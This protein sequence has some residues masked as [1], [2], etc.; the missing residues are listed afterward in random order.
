MHFVR[1]GAAISAAS[2]GIGTETIAS[3]GR[4]RNLETAAHY[5]RAARRA[6]SSVA[7]GC[8]PTKKPVL[9]DDKN[10][11]LDRIVN[12]LSLNDHNSSRGGH[13]F[14]TGKEVGISGADEPKGPLA[15]RSGAANPVSASAN[16]C[17]IKK[18]D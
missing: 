7:L 2:A 6:A 5:E 16:I 13:L 3:L 14:Q 11:T 17:G 18:N 15:G 12:K 4:W 8:W 1:I 9:L 10:K